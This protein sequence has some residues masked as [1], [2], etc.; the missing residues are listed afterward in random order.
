MGI[1][2]APFI[3]QKLITVALD[4]LRLAHGQNLFLWIDDILNTNEEGEI[5]ENLLPLLEELG[6]Y[7]SW[8]KFKMGETIDYTGYLIDLKNQ[9]IKIGAKAIRKLTARIDEF[10]K[11]QGFTQLESLV[12]SLEFAASASNTGRTKVF[13][14]LSLL[15][16]WKKSIDNGKEP[17]RSLS[18]KEEIIQ[19]LEYWKSAE[20]HPEMKIQKLSPISGRAS[21][22]AWSDASLRGW[23]VKVGQKTWSGSF[24]DS[25]PTI[26]Q[27]LDEENILNWRNS[28]QKL[29]LPIPSAIRK[30]FGSILYHK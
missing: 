10:E 13:H 27:I 29:R 16:E 19:E 21:V 24:E 28:R 22:R 14:L 30:Y 25:N 18:K 20:D 12:G 8:D 17:D 15:N 6:I 26:V 9:T 1:S 4:Y 23:G 5:E 2:S 7:V 11:D 3:C